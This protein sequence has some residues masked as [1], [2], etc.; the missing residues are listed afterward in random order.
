MTK[1]IDAIAE[2]AKFESWYWRAYGEDLR[3]RRRATRYADSTATLAW[4]S[5]LGALSVRNRGTPTGFHGDF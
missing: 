1:T 5:W 4:R 3:P 2:R